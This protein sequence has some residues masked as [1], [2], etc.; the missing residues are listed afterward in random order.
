MAKGVPEQFIF[1]FGC[2]E[3]A[4]VSIVNPYGR[5]L[6]KVPG[7]ELLSVAGQEGGCCLTRSIGEKLRGLF[8]SKYM[9]EWFDHLIEIFRS[10]EIVYFLALKDVKIRYKFSSLGFLWAVIFPL[11]Q[12][13]ILSIVFTWV[14]RFKINAYPAFLLIGLLPWSFF[15][16]SLNFTTTTMLDHSNLIKKIYFPRDI[17]PIAQVLSNLFDYCVALTVLIP[18]LLYFNIGFSQHL[19]FLPV[20]LLIQVVMTTGICLIL[21]SLTVIYRDIKY[22][23]ELMLMFGFYAS[24]VFYPATFIKENM[25]EF[26]YALYFLNPM[27]G[28]ISMYRHSLYYH[29]S[30]PPLV[31]LYTAF[32]SLILLVVG[33]TVFNRYE[34]RFADLV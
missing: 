6:D 18:F 23:K 4:K 28:L 12:M 8:R 9:S 2:I 25:G 26:A 31:V 30:T 24:P 29:T 33:L 16:I 20:A 17:I 32:T 3:T 21:S 22:I 14:V 19:L 5:I 27:T 1:D 7:S 15:S 10:R 34:R 13:I 11:G